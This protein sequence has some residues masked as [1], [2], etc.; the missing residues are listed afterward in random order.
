MA[1]RGIKDRVAIIGMGCT[2]FGEH[3]DKGPEDLLV[4]A[5][6]QA[7]ESAG[8][9]PNDVDA[10]WLGTMGFGS[11]GP[12]AERAAQDSV[13]AGHSRREHVRDRF[14]G[15]ARKPAMRSRRARSTWRW[16][17]ASRSSRTRATRAWS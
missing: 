9:E 10:Y 13:Q 8:V 12:D 15:A 16:L 11:L 14:R 5:A 1:S 3:W 7:Y 17:S 2:K 4:D 6:Y